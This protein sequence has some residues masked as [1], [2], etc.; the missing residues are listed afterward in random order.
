M[1]ITIEVDLT[2][3]EARQIMGLPDVQPL[4]NAILAEIHDDVMSQAKRFS[5]EG[6]INNWLSHSAGPFGSALGDLMSF[7][8]SAERNTA[9]SKSEPSR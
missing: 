6:L 1:K 2:P 4:Q 5:A 7:G 9:S 3:A 8:R